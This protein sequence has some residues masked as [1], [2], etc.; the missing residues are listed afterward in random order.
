[1]TGEVDYIVPT[2]I[3]RFPFR[4]HLK[5]GELRQHCEEYCQQIYPMLTETGYDLELAKTK[6]VEC[7]SVWGSYI[8]PDGDIEVMKVL[9]R[10]WIAWTVIDDIIDNTTDP[11]SIDHL[12]GLLTSAINGEVINGEAP[13]AGMFIAAKDFFSSDVWSSPAR[14]LI[15][16][17]MWGYIEATRHIRA[18]EIEKKTLSYDQY[19]SIRKRNVTVPALHMHSNFVGPDLSEEMRNIRYSDNFRQA[20]DYSSEAIALM[21]DLYQLRGGHEEIAEYTNAVRIIRRWSGGEMA[22]QQTVDKLVSRFYEC[23]ENLEAELDAIAQTH[24]AVVK[25]MMFVQAG[26]TLFLRDLRD[27]RYA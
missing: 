2:L 22:W 12:L 5:Y 24:P 15:K 21:A 8:H 27:S 18:I 6:L 17:E 23:E 14:E 1:M 13:I 25:S 20:L 11:K 16:S 10:W 19:M 4:Q 9:A 3:S 7:G 26:I